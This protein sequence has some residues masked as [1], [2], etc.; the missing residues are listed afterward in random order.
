MS[1][2]GK[3]KEKKKESSYIV[4]IIVSEGSENVRWL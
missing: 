2:E 1:K 4:S 3:K